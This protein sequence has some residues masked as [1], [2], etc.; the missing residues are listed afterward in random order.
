MQKNLTLQ[1]APNL[2][3]YEPEY[4]WAFLVVSTISKQLDLDFQPATVA[5]C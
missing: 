2:Y 4:H 5:I 1:E 3:V